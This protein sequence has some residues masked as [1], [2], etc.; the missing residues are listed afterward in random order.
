VPFCGRTARARKY[1]DFSSL[2]SCRF[3]SRG[4]NAPFPHFSATLSSLPVPP[5][6]L[7]SVWIFLPLDSAPSPVTRRVRET[8]L[9]AGPAGINIPA[10]LLKIK[11]IARSSEPALRLFETAKLDIVSGGRFSAASVGVPWSACCEAA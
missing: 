1:S 8:R 11:P 7:P 4:P 3:S 10:V 5:F 6:H 9:R 2:F